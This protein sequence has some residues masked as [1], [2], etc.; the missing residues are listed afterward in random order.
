MNGLLVMI[1]M[2]CFIT[3]EKFLKYFQ[4]YSIVFVGGSGSCYV[5]SKVWIQPVRF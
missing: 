2:N 3:N 4:V 1:D 5:A